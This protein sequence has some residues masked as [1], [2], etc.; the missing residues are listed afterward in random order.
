M[1]RATE[2]A[3]LM[4]EQLPPLKSKSDS[5]LEEGAPYPPEP[6]HGDW[7]PRLKV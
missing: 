2:T 7:R 1:N 3:Q 4:M 5:I 6:K